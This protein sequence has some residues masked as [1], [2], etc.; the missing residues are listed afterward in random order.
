MSLLATL[1]F[2]QQ[3]F[4]IFLLKKC[5]GTSPIQFCARTRRDDSEQRR[6]LSLPKSPE[7]QSDES[8]IQVEHVGH[9]PK[10]SSG[11][12]GKS[13]GMSGTG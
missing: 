9:S 2:F 3:F 13:F 4:F 1:V 6:R 8:P 10:K 7:I 12:V 5:T 11:H